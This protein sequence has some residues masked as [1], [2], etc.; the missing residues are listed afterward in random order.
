MIRLEAYSGEMAYSLIYTS[1]K[2]HR[3]KKKHTMSLSLIG[4]I[5]NALGGQFPQ[6]DKT[7]ILL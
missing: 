6:T 4:L 3:P 7:D 1:W 5:D 2:V